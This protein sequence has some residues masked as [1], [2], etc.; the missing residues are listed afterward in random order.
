MV[1]ALTLKIITCRSKV[2]Q[3]LEGV[4]GRYIFLRISRYLY[5]FHTLYSVSMEG[6]VS[7]FHS[8]ARISLFD[9]DILKVQWEQGEK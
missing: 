6:R 4:V 9:S 1:S 2:V 7:P 5:V 3:E 8:G